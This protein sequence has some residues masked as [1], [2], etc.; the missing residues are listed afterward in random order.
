MKGFWD[1][2]LI[3]IAFRVFYKHVGNFMPGFLVQRRNEM[4]KAAKKSKGT[5]KWFSNQK[6]YGF[7]T[8]EDGQDLFAHYSDI[9]GEGFRSLNEGQ[10]VEYEIGEN[11]KG[12]KAMNIVPVA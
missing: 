6:G 9:K 2:V 12:K 8:G 11:D 1:R 5:V 10:E 4:A 7:I 3:Q